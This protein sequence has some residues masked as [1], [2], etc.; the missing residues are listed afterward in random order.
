M[1]RLMGSPSPVPVG[2]VEQKGSN[3][4]FTIEAFTQTHLGGIVYAADHPD[5]YVSSETR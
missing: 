5:L 4:R 3:I 2:F 1:V